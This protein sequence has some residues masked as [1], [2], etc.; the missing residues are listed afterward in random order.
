VTQNQLADAD[1]T[2]FIMHASDFNPLVKKPDKESN[3]LEELATATYPADGS[4]T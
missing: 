2:K 1:N 4:W 3:A